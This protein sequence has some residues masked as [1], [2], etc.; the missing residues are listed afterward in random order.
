MYVPLLDLPIHSRGQPKFYQMVPASS[1]CPDH[2]NCNLYVSFT[3]I[4]AIE[5]HEIAALRQQLSSAMERL[6]IGSYL[7]GFYCLYTDRENGEKCLLAGSP[8]VCSKNNF[9]NVRYWTVS[10]CKS[11]PRADPV[12]QPLDGK[13]TCTSVPW[14]GTGNRSSSLGF[15][16]PSDT[17]GRH[18][19]QVQY[20][21][22]HFST[23]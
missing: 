23:I 16:E 2:W 18:Y 5:Q 20:P 13:S 7:V 17:V 15:Y 22:I 3:D 14:E 6:Q 4:S 8:A 11:Q 1:N 9:P 10:Y 21:Q 19:P 12:N